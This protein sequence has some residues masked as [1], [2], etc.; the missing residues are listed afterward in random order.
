MIFLILVL[1]S[2][3]VLFLNFNFHSR[4]I[5]KLLRNQG[6]DEE[7]IVRWEKY[8]KEKMLKRL[9]ESLSTKPE[10]EKSKIVTLCH[11]DTW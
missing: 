9:V 8:A 1:N 11:G 10:M 3:E 4:S 6:K 5:S 2:L 7:L